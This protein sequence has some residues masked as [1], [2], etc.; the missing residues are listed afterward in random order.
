MGRN[1][2]YKSELP[3]SKDRKFVLLSQAIKLLK[4]NCLDTSSC[5]DC[6]LLGPK[7]PHDLG[8]DIAKFNCPLAFGETPEQWE[9]GDMKDEIFACA[10]MD[11]WTDDDA[12]TASTLCP[13]QPGTYEKVGDTWMRT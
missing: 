11:P 3:M 7:L 10:T 4:A 13:N 2:K 6:I 9:L 8:V 12:P 1:P 5:K